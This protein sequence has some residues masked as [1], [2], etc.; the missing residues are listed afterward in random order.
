M[1]LEQGTTYKIAYVAEDWNGVLGEVKFVSVT[2][3]T[4][5]GG[6]NPEGKIELVNENGKYAFKFSIVKEAASFKYLVGY[7]EAEAAVRYIGVDRYSDMMK[8]WNWFATDCGLTAKGHLS[9]TMDVDK[10]QL[11]NGKCVALMIAIGTDALGGEVYGELEHLIYDNGEARTLESYY[12]DMATPAQQAAVKASTKLNA[13]YALSH[14][15]VEV[16]RPTMVVKPVSASD[17]ERLPRVV[18]VGKTLHPKNIK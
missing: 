7:N 18:R 12:P 8:T 4:L 14:Q 10:N 9:T 3:P 15:S 6:L 1:V 2:T 11:V 13:V 5:I 17:V 16:E